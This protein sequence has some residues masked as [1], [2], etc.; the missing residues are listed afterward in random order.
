MPAEFAPNFQI[1][2]SIALFI[3]AG[4][5]DGATGCCLVPRPGARGA[6]LLLMHWRFHADDVSRA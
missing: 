1:N 6:P 3:I 2:L 5:P 4:V